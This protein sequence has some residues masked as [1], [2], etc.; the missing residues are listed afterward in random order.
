MS[1]LGCCCCCCTVI[2]YW[3][4][5]RYRIEMLMRGIS[6]CRLLYSPWAVSC[7]AYGCTLLSCLGSHS[8]PTGMPSELNTM[9]GTGKTCIQHENV[10]CLSCHR[11]RS[12]R[13]PCLLVSRHLCDRREIDVLVAVHFTSATGKIPPRSINGFTDGSAKWRSHPDK[14]G[15]V[16]MLG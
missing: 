11:P 1:N 6:P 13:F 3:L 4:E 12:E 14:G 5:S 2:A 16:P 10:T 7:Q 15:T 9:V 8:H